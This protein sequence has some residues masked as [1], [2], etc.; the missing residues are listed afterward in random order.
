MDTSLFSGTPL[1][2]LAL[3]L[4]AVGAALVVAPFLG[5]GARRSPAVEAEIVLDAPVALPAAADFRQP[6][7]AFRAAHRSIAP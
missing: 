2:A 7:S 3:T 5:V 1:L 4:I 6:V